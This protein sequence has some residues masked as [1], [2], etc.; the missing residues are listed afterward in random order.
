M[1]PRIKMGLVVG[2][3]GLAI[4]V[5]VAGFIGLCG[6]IVSL[7]AGGVAG[8]LAAQQEK[9]STKNEGAKAGAISGG[10]AGALVII[11]Q[12]IGG[13]VALA[14]MQASGNQLPFGT[15]PSS[16]DTANTVIY[17]ISG[18]GT[19]LCFGIVGAALAAGAGASAGYLATP[20]QPPASSSM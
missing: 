3:I 5:C 19:G 1:Q 20:D 17:Y 18:I 7:L 10:I 4:N 14:I 11:G 9:L 6:P 8:F 12:V 15:I 16:G 2:V 13:V